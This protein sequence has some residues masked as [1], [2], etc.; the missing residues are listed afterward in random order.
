MKRSSRNPGVESRGR[1]LIARRRW[2][3]L[4]LAGVL[5][6]S[7]SACHSSTKTVSAV[8]A[9]LTSATTAGAVPA[10]AHGG[11]TTV[12][13]RGP[14]GNAATSSTRS[15]LPSP[16]ATTV[17]G[18]PSTS[19]TKPAAPSETPGGECRSGYPLANVYHAYRLHIVKS[20]LAVTGTVE[21][22]RREDD[23]D[24]HVEL[25]LPANE[26][27]LLD[28]ANV[29]DE[30]GHLVTVIVPADQPDCTPGEP[31]P[32]PP[33][34]Y[35]SYSYSYGICTGAD[36]ATPALGARVVVTGPYVLDADHGWMEIHPVWSVTLEG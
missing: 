3:T 9:G 31:P 12:V 29:A 16:A 32:L 21:Y 30:Y 23:G 11:T 34:A 14:V 25:S 10:A 15:S 1:P 19:A 20:C 2:A 8:Q 36:V 33:T 24:V 17:S 5:L 27:H 26:S 13:S 22:V 18:S 35:R 4:P 28:A 6:L 7:L